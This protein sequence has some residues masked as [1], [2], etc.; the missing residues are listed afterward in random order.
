MNT[1][2]FKRWIRLVEV[3]IAGGVFWACTGSDDDGGFAG[4]TTEDAGI[5]ADLNV[6]GVAQK[7]PFVKGSVVTVQGV[8]C[9]TMKFTG[10]RFES[11]VKSER[12]DFE[13][14]DINL[15]SMCAVFEVSGYYLNEVSGQKSSGLVR[16]RTV[17]NLKNRNNVNVNVLTSLEYARV[18]RLAL[19]RKMLFDEAKAQAEKEVLASFEIEGDFAKAED[20]DIFEKGESNAALLAMSVL[21]ATSADETEIYARLDQYAAAIAF[22][23]TLDD[24]VKTKMANCAASAVS[25]G[26]L[27]SIR[28]NIESWGYTDEVPA[29]ETYVK[30]FAESDRATQSSSSAGL[31]SLSSSSFSII[32]LDWD[33]DVPLA[34]RFNP[35]IKYDTMIDPRDNQVYKIVKIAPDGADYSQVWMA[36]N[37]NYADS[38]KTPSLKGR[39]WCYNDNE[40]YCEVSGRYYSWM[41]AIDSAKLAVDP[42]S[43][44]DCGYGKKCGLA[45]SVQGICPDGW[46]LPTRHEL[47]KLIVALGNSEIA[48]RHLKALTGW[49]DSEEG[50]GIDSCGFTALPVGRRLEDGS[51]Q[52][53]GTD[54]YFWSTTE[55]D[56][57]YTINAAEYMNMNNIY[58]KAYMYQG[59]KRY[60]QSVRCVKD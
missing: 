19:E 37:L 22:N 35:N 31:A 13:V 55:Y 11:V 17:T 3:L 7:G 45:R 21:L 44:L 20:M 56:S 39:N 2:L 10:E 15:S 54:D 52:K 5:I 34:A 30:D 27:D 41:A 38:I 14:K 46:H 16:L 1:L 12:G 24:S 18:W 58:T 23:G 9:K 42:D 25:S 4:G 6:A 53:V 47:G 49:G 50:S 36:Q 40:K 51:Y 57:E 59:D 60:G 32:S 8:D 48:G 43:A 26:K 33:W 29:F 28:K